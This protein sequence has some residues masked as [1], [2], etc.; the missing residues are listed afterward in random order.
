VSH[1]VLREACHLANVQPLAAR[2]FLR[3]LRALWHT[4]GRVRDAMSLL[5][6]GDHRTR[7]ALVERSGL[8]GD[9]GA[10]LAFEEFLRVQRFIEHGHPALVALHRMVDAE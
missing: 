9:E 10:V 4:G 3:V 6:V 5:M 1:S 8:V 7:A 2:D